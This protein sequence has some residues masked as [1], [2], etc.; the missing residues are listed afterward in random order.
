MCKKGFVISLSPLTR[1]KKPKDKRDLVPG[2]LVW[3]AETGKAKIISKEAGVIV[4]DLIHPHPVPPTRMSIPLV[5]A[6]V[7]KLRTE[8]EQSD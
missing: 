6:H 5:C 7:L 2:D 1:Q 4:L 3:Y 8:T